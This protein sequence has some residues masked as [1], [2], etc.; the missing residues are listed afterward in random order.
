MLTHK[1]TYMHTHVSSMVH[2]D[3]RSLAG[4]FQQQIPENTH[5]YFTDA[6]K[7]ER[8]VT[9]KYVTFTPKHI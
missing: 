2:V 8:A 1:Q 7:C 3:Y 5:S 6:S 4:R 9:L